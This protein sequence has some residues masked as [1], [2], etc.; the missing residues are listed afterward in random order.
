MSQFDPSNNVRSGGKPQA[1]HS[2][3]VNPSETKPIVV[4][5]LGELNLL[6][7]KLYCLKDTHEGPLC[8][9]MHVIGIGAANRDDV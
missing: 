6:W 5:K 1:Q 8:K 3:V 7:L 2:I 4:E 9:G